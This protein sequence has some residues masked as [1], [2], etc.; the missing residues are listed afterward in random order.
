V[1]GSLLLRLTELAHDGRRVYCDAP[2][3]IA[4]GLTTH[5]K[6]HVGHN[7]ADPGEWFRIDRESS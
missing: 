5:S 2:T 3:V 7:A 4:R 1:A 6:L